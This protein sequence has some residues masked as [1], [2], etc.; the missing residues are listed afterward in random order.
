MMSLP[1]YCIIRYAV[2]YLQTLSTYIHVKMSLSL[3]HILFG[4]IVFY[5]FL[6]SI[7]TCPIRRSMSMQNMLWMTSFEGF[8]QMF[9]FASM[10][11]AMA[12]VEF[13]AL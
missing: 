4:I 8:L 11:P 12:I 2:L 10:C 13:I 7:G 3:V 5:P 6:V 9:Q 1:D